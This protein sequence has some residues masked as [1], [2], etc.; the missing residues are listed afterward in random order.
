M[1]LDEI[2]GVIAREEDRQEFRNLGRRYRKAADPQ[3]R[4]ADAMSAA[5][6]GVLLDQIMERLQWHFRAARFPLPTRDEVEKMIIE[7]GD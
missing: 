3:A 6:R 2:V 1:E 4:G 5:E 7:G